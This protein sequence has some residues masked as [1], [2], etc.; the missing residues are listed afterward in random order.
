MTDAA[1]VWGWR[2][3]KNFVFAFGAV[4]PFAGIGVLVVAVDRGL[5]L[6]RMLS[7]AVTVVGLLVAFGIGYASDALP[8]RIARH[9]LHL[10]ANVG[11]MVFLF[12]GMAVLTVVAILAYLALPSEMQPCPF[13]PC[14]LSLPLFGAEVD[15]SASFVV[16]PERLLGGFATVGTIVTVVGFAQLFVVML[17]PPRFDP[18]PLD[19][20]TVGSRVLARVVDM[21]VLWFLSYW[22]LIY[23]IRFVGTVGLSGWWAV[24]FLIV[25]LLL[26]SLAYEFVP[27]LMWNGSVGKLLVGLRVTAIN[28]EPL[29]WRRVL[30]RSMCTSLLFSSGTTLAVF[31]LTGDWSRDTLGWQLLAAFVGILTPALHVSG[32]SIPDI[33]AYTWVVHHRAKPDRDDST[34]PEIPD[35]RWLQLRPEEFTADPD[36]PFANDLLARRGDVKALANT[37]LQVSGSTVVLVNA[38]WGGGKTAF[39]RMCSAYLDSRDVRVVE[40]NAWTDQHIKRPLVDLVGAISQQV[41]ESQAQLLKSK[42][43]PLAKLIIPRHSDPNLTLQT[44]QGLWDSWTN[45]SKAVDDFAAALSAA[46]GEDDRLVVIIDE[47]D[48][49]HPTYALDTL[50]VVHHLFAVPGVIV[51]LGVNRDGLCRS[52]EAVYGHGFDADSYLRR[53]SDLQ[54]DISPPTP[55]QLVPFLDHLLENTGLNKQ[56]ADPNGAKKILHLITE[57]NTCTLRDVQQAARIAGLMLTQPTPDNH[58]A[59]VWELSA[60][61]LILLRLADHDAYKEFVNDRINSFEALASVSAALPSHPVTERPP[62]E[63]YPR[64]TFEASLLNMGSDHQWN[65]QGGS[66]ATFK[67]TYRSAHSK[68]NGNW[69]GSGGTPADAAEVLD[70]LCQLRSIYRKPPGWIPLKQATL[71]SLIDRVAI[72]EPSVPSPAAPLKRNLT[73]AS[74]HS[75]HHAPE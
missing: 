34:G 8:R 47:L 15:G 40:F 50:A 1:P 46:K 63:P 31:L 71:A 74:L 33:F 56:L 7:A 49:C 52:V 43:S 66:A 37:V 10:E 60:L 21:V 11:V 17:R 13:G 6:E 20:K 59:I 48:R 68:P 14:T 35:I 38:P 36:E 39:L 73:T 53:F 25:A 45:S 65:D 28:D 16:S 67:R 51:L 69:N 30:L 62:G 42:A 19:S 41:P 32:Q 64:L 12:F 23:G 70:R 26:V 9:G 22:T 29:T 4:L 27:L 18:D 55:P 54:H 5:S 75:P 57:L 61:A 72:W 2:G 44:A 58:P 3:F 24:S